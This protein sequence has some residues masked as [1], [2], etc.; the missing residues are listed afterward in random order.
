[1]P[2]DVYFLTT[3]PV[4]ITIWDF[5]LI[6]LGTLFICTFASLFPAMKAARIKPVDGIRYG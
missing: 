2:G 1:L 6:I 3:L 4:R 5:G